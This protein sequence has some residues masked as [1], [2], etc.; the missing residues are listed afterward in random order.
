M[1]KRTQQV[2]KKENIDQKKLLGKEMGEKMSIYA[3]GKC[4]ANYQLNFIQFFH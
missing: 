2:E 4:R 1:N 3:V